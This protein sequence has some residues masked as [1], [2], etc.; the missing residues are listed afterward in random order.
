MKKPVDRRYFIKT[1][2]AGSVSI[3]LVGR[4]FPHDYFQITQHKRIGIIG[5]DTSHSV[6][7]AK[8]LNGPSPDPVFKGYRIAAAYPKGSI[9][10]PSSVER[11]P[12]Y[13]EDV[14]LLG[15]EIVNS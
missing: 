6:A 3:G 14:K 2:V 11:I 10:I 9:D 5:L 7:F 12:G 1:A 8:A 15:V 4:S 13:T